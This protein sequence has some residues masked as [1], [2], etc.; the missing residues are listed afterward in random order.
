MRNLTDAQIRALSRHK[1]PKVL[2]K[3]IKRTQ[4]QIIE[5]THKRHANRPPATA[6][7][8]VDDGQLSF[9]QLLKSEKK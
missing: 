4:A 2:R 3:Y 8:A 9:D 6:P 1:S 5:G 7:G